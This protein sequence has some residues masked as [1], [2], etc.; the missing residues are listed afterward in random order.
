MSEHCQIV[1]ARAEGG[2]GAEGH[3]VL[4]SLHSP[5]ASARDRR[6]GFIVSHNAAQGFPGTC[7]SIV[8]ADE[9]SG[10]CCDEGGADRMGAVRTGT[11]SHAS[12]DLTSLA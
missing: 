11:S 10:P 5:S 6:S 8:F 12:F 9:L 4:R 3:F 2:T 1:T 7:G